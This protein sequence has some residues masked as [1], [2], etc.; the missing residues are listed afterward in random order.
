ML[1]NDHV[2]GQDQNIG[3]EVVGDQDQD[4]QT[5][6]TTPGPD[7]RRKRGDT[8][9]PPP[10]APVEREQKLFRQKLLRRRKLIL[11]QLTTPPPPPPRPGMWRTSRREAAG[12]GARPASSCQGSPLRS[13]GLRSG[14]R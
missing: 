6:E 2:T 13:V 8:A 4:P 12:P 1:P 11:S 10:P 5:G 7:T 9:P 3:T 14:R